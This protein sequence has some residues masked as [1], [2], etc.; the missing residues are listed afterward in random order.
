MNYQKVLT[1]IDKDRLIYIP[2]IVNECGF[3]DPESVQDAIYDAIK[4]DIYNK[5]NLD[6]FINYVVSS[7]AYIDKKDDLIKLIRGE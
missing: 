3:Q 6:I 2:K 1:Q 4:G 7:V 5:Y